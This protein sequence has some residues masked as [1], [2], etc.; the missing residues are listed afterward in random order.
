MNEGSNL[1]EL[2]VVL[3]GE[4][5]V[6]KTSIISKFMKKIFQVDLQSSTVGTL[7]TKTFIYNGNKLLKLEIWDT[8]GQERYRSLTKMFYK[9]ASVAIMVYDITRKQ[10]Y[11]EIK[12][13]WADE[14]SNNA[15]ENIIKVLCANKSDLI[16]DET[17][18][19]TEAREYAKS[20]GA[21]FHQTSAKNS[22]GINELFLDI[23]KKA[24]NDENVKIK[25][26]G[27]NDEGENEAVDEEP[28][29]KFGSVKI[30]KK[31]DMK[32]P[33]KGCC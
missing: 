28:Q 17:V 23:A 25:E 4:S 21:L 1:K 22:Y 9:E 31:Q 10:T 5:E 20:I 11:E 33:K 13:Y 8:A 24:T 18:D 12:N 32:K 3:V 6:G 27:E 26:D 19:E 16:D 29:D 30:S 7:S 15:P 14:I 2:K